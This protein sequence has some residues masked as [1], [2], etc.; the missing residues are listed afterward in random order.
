MATPYGATYGRG[1]ARMLP[2]ADWL[3]APVVH[4]VCPRSF[5][6][7]DGGGAG[8]GPL[9]PGSGVRLAGQIVEVDGLGDAV[10]AWP[11]S[12]AC[13]RWWWD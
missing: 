6:D 5:A 8:A 7:S 13:R 1:P 10:P 3:A 2:V 9:L 12:P 11:W 4:E